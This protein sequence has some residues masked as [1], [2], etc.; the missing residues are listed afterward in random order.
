M[1]KWKTS[2]P[3]ESQGPERDRGSKG[4]WNSG[5]KAGEKTAGLK[6]IRPE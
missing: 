1:N 6:P 5:K 2:L 3:S 4:R